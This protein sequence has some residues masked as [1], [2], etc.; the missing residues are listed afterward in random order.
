MEASTAS[1]RSARLTCHPAT[2]AVAVRGTDVRVRRA[3][4][5]SF[6]A[7]SYRHAVLRIGPSTVVEA[8]DGARSYW[9]LR[10]PAAKPDFHRPDAFTMLLEAP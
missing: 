2:P 5:G 9:A 4:A 6:E 8:S 10:H 7:E 1:E 3:T